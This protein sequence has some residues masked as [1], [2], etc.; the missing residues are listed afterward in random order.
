MLRT[1]LAV[2][3]LLLLLLLF[4]LLLQSYPD[5]CC[6]QC[7]YIYSHIYSYSFNWNYFTWHS[8]LRCRPTAAWATFFKAFDWPHVHVYIAYIV[9]CPLVGCVRTSACV[10]VCICV[11]EVQLKPA[12]RVS[13]CCSSLA[14]FFSV[15]FSSAEKEGQMLFLDFLL[16]KKLCALFWK[17]GGYTCSLY[18]CILF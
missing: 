14:S 3:L 4:L 10:C 15:L 1:A 16:P 12:Y 2:A 11:C 7:N 9:A 5:G 6:C 8:H 13:V 17:V 18:T